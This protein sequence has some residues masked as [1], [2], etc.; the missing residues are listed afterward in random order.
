MNRYIYLF[1]VVVIGWAPLIGQE[2]VDLTAQDDPADRSKESAFNSAGTS[3][4]LVGGGAFYVSSP[5]PAYEVDVEKAYLSPEFVPL[6]IILQDGVEHELPG[7]IRLIDQ[8]VEVR[9]EDGEVYDLDNRVV[10]A[11][12]DPQERVYVSG[13]DPTGR[14]KGTHL[15][16]V[17]Y[18]DSLHRLLVN[19]ATVWEDPPQQHMFDTS[20]PRKTLKRVVRNYYVGE[21]GSAEIERLNDLLVALGESKRGP[22]GRMVK[23]YRLKNDTEGYVALLGY[24]NERQE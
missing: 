21:H 19:T 4:A 6:S 9:M 16:E 1:V 13:F 20:E 24:L 17:A 18:I 5:P 12:V 15:Y 7:R 3:A 8:K 2:P 10:R 22:V 23:K 14:I 11:V